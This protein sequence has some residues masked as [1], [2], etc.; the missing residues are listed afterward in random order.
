[1]PRAGLLSS[2]LPQAKDE[3]DRLVQVEYW[4]KFDFTGCVRKLLPSQQ[5]VGG[6]RGMKEVH[7]RGGECVGSLPLCG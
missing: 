4:L 2:L 6:G 1:V 5:Q 7:V 3:L